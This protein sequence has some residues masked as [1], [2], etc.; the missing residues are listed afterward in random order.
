MVQLTITRGTGDNIIDG[1][2]KN[3]NES[4]TLASAFFVNLLDFILDQF[5]TS[6][7]VVTV[8]I[9]INNNK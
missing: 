5:N 2:M 6:L 1:K 8:V 7:L 4:P 9:I 3:K